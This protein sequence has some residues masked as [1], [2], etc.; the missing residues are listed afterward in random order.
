MCLKNPQRS[1]P[2]LALALSVVAVVAVHG[3]LIGYRTFANVDEAYAGAL[4]SRLLDGHKLYVGAVSQRGPLMY[5]VYELVGWLHGWDNIVGLRL[6]ALCFAILNLLA[7][8]F[9]ARAFLSRGGVVAA[10]LVMGY[11]LSFGVP[12]SDG[13]ALHGEALQ[14]PALTFGTL[15]GAL[16]M[17]ARHGS[18]RRQLLLFA[19]GTLL[20]VAVAVKQSAALHPIP[21]LV[22]LLVDARRAGRSPRTLLREVA[23][24]AAG[25]ALVPAAFLLHAWATGTLE[26][27]YYYTVVYNRQIHLRPTRKLYPILTPFFFRF[28]EQTSYFLALALVA[29]AAV[30]RL[31]ARLRSAARSR[32]LASLGRGF[33]FKTFNGLNLAIA[34]LSASA[35]Y[36]FF[37]HYYVQTLPFLALA[38]ASLVEPLV[39]RRRN[40]AYTRA[41][42]VAAMGFLLVA[43]TLGCVFGE[44][45]DGRVTHDRTPQLCGKIIEATTRPEDRIFVWGF[46]PWIYQYAHR[47][48]AGRFVFETYVTGFVPWFWDRLEVEKARIVPGSVEALLD[49]L[50]REKPEIVVDAG[51]VMMARPMRGYA[52]PGRW[53]AEHYCFELR[54]GPFDLYRRKAEGVARCAQP[55]FPLPH[56]AVN[57]S[58]VTMGIPLPISFDRD[59]ERRLPHGNFLKPIWFPHG[60]RPGPEVFE[61]VRDRNLER[62]EEEAERDGFFI[63][64]SEGDMAGGASAP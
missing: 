49:D 61:V 42:S 34:V 64:R 32:S 5:Y 57:W 23:L 45:I 31:A 41:V 10:T 8:F 63:P 44:R 36:R 43:A 28:T 17:R 6:W 50:E 11:A 47:K 52:K 53:L 14:L 4:A 7:V 46:S 60:P 54:I 16:A 1:F 62:E 22:W 27:L 15:V 35:M 55:Y 25:T 9:T 18:R 12:A 3:P 48:P 29:A 40:G 38:L 56:D 20:G 37:P 39:R 26:E 59:N 24:L 21:L 19:S 30:P 2:L 13:L 33:G 58:G 51:S